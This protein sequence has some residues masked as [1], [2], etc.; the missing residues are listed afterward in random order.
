MQESQE[1]VS[2]VGSIIARVE[3]LGQSEK[4]LGVDEEVGQFKDGFGIRDAVLLKVTIEAAP[5]GP[6]ERQGRQAVRTQ[7]ESHT[8][9]QDTKEQRARS[10]A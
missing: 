8:P 3:L 9:R 4:W 10:L 2:I 1:I 6:A 7:G 5:W